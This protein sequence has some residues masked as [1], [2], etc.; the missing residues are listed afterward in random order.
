MSNQHDLPYRYAY[1][2]PAVTTDAVVFTLLD[3]DLAVLLIRRG[4][5]PFKGMWALPGGFLTPTEDLDTCAR[6]E[7]EEETGVTLSD[8]RH[9]ANFSAPDRDPRERVISAAYWALTPSDELSPRGGTDADEARWFLTDGLPELAFDH[10][11]IFEGAQ[12]ALR[13]RCEAFGILFGLLPANFTLTAF[14]AAYEAVMGEAA[15]RRNLHKAVLASGL[16]TATGEMSGGRH[17]PAR[18]FRAAGRP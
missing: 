9:F 18:L 17:R 11:D 15:D 13:A 16:V 7:L 1:A 10:A 14:Q 6:R 2:H 12:K 4:G 5:E 8:L 3:G